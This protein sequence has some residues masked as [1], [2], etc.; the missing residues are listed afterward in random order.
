MRLGLVFEPSITVLR[1]AVEQ[2]TLLWGG[3]Y[4]PFY[5]PSDIREF[6]S[7]PA[8]LGVDVLWPVDDSLASR[9]ASEVDG[10]RWRGREEFGPLSSAKEYGNYRLLGPERFLD[11]SNH[12][13]WVLPRWDTEDP[14][15]DV[16][17]VW[18]GSYDSSDQALRLESDF[19]AR[20]T[21]VPI[22]PTASIPA[23][24]PSWIPPILATGSAIDYAGETPG[25]G[26]MVVDPSD[27]ASL[28]ALWNL[29]ACG[30]KVFPW[31]VNNED[32]VLPAAR[33]WLQQLLADGNLNRWR[34]GDGKSL[35]P[36]IE[37]WLI[38]D[39][40]KPSSPTQPPPQIEPPTSLAD[41][42]AEVGVTPMTR[43]SD[44]A[45]ELAYG[46]RGNHPFTTRFSNDFA[47]PVEEDERTVNIPLPRLPDKIVQPNRPRGDVAAAQLEVSS[48]SRFRADWT[49]SAPNIRT[50][51]PFLSN[52]DGTLL[53]F[54][55]PTADGRALSIFSRDQ[56]VSISAVPSIAVFGKLIEASGWEGRQTRG[57]I[58]VTRLI[59]RLGGS[60]STIANQPG[61]RAG[62]M[63]AAKSERG[64][65]SGAIVQRIKQYQGSWP[66]PF[67]SQQMRSDYPGS[68][69]RYL[70]ARGILRPTLPVACPYCTTTIPVRPEDLATQMKCEMC[71]RDF[72]LGL[73]L[74]ATVSGRN[75]WLYQ[76]AGHVGQ[77]RLSEALAVMA[78]LQVLTSSWHASPSTF[79]YV[80]GWEVRGPSLD[81][82]ID[83]AIILNERG[84][85]IVIIGEAKHHSASIDAND[86]SNLGKVQSHLREKGIECFVLT[87]V[88]REELRQEEVEVLRTFAD[89]P[90]TT[91]P[92][93]SSIEPVLPIVLTEKDLSAHQFDEHPMSWAPV[94]GTVGF[95]KESC[96]R[97]LGMTSL[98][99]AIDA[100]GFYFRPGWS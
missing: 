10:Y 98:D 17:R 30:A 12:E 49:F 32:R 91:L 45:W 29:R 1:L 13:D 4:Q 69:F 72:P 22:D 100:N 21:I 27:A 97:N 46:W 78:T 16:F 90:P 23:G 99:T 47:Q 53:Q 15:E 83:I 7:L 2:A 88:L 96:R 3:L 5:R 95:A 76:L 61:A 73:A 56:T 34:S 65:P 19:A 54:D 8:R 82:E 35:S 57:G 94:D 67:V 81:C 58:F 51:A 79:P 33:Q 85:P 25:A 20:S 41:L 62:L 9:Q 55:R 31:T 87:A 93:R 39:P 70:L 75:D 28:M 66:G 71:L 68:V 36:M 60:G 38:A 92:P 24:V 86:L 84:L 18:F 77:S 80:L 44:D 63:E 14:L 74:G 48:V 37:V 52:Y 11:D 26:F 6:K 64:R 89:R 42:L 43:T 59:E 50:L 40:R